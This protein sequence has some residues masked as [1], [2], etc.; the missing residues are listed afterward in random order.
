MNGERNMTEAELTLK[1]LYEL[2]LHQSIY[3]PEINRT[4]YRV[5]GGWIYEGWSLETGKPLDSIFVPFSPKG[6]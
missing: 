6:T 4:V 2:E 5:P 3:I 1:H